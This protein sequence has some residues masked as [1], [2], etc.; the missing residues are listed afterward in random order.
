M[1]DTGTTLS[2]VKLAL[3]ARKQQEAR[4]ADPAIAEPLAIVGMGCRFPGGAE[5][6]AAFWELLLEGRST[7]REIPAERW[8][9]ADWYSSS[10]AAGKIGTAYASMLDG[11]DLFDPVFFGISPREA[12]QMDPQQRLLLEVASEALDDAGLTLDGLRS[13]RTGVFMAVFNADYARQQLGNPREVTQH[14]LAGGARSMASGRLSFL[15][16][17]QGP[18]ITV[19][20][21]CSSSLVAIHLACQ[22]L[23]AGES[24]TAIAG[25]VSLRLR[26][27]EIVALSKLGMLAPDG[28]SKTFDSSA[29]GFGI[30]EGCGVLVLKRLSDA[31]RRNDPV[32]AVIRGTAVNQDG[33]TNALTAPNGLAQQEL[34]RAALRN[35]SIPG[36]A[37]SLIEA[38]GTGTRLGD[39]IEVGALA[40]VVGA[41]SEGA[42]PCALTS[43]KATIGHLEAAAGVAGL[44]RAVLSL[45][46]ET[47]SP[48]GFFRELNPEISLEPTRFFIPTERKA[49]PRGASPRFAGISSFGFSGTNAH[50]IVEEAPA[51]PASH[52][53]G[54]GPQVL[55]V[56]ARSQK[57][58]KELAGRYARE[59]RGRAAGVS[60]DDA[61]YTVNL[62][63]THHE[64]RAAAVVNSTGEAADAFAAIAAESHHPA[65]FR[66]P[67]SYAPGRAAFVFSG[68][69]AQWNRM[70][71]GLYE[72]EPE[73]RKALDECA[74]GILHQA[75]WSLLEVLREEGAGSRLDQTEFAQPAIFSIQIALARLWQA[76]G[77]RP[78][79]VVG[80]SAGE[81]AAAC[82]AGAL[83]LPEAIRVIVS[84]GRVM[85]AATGKGRMAAIALPAAEVETKI[86]PWAGRVCIG[87]INSPTSCVISGDIDIFDDVLAVF[88]GFVQK[89]PV[90]YAFHSHQMKPLQTELVRALGTVETRVPQIPVFSTLSGRAAAE[91]FDA[92]YWARSM[93]EPVRFADAVADMGKGE[94][95][96]FIEIA[97]HAVLST[98]VPQ[99]LADRPNTLVISSMK[100]ATDERTAMLRAAA[101]LHA[102]GHG[103]TW[104]AI[105]PGG[106]CIPLPSYP[107][108]RQRYRL[109]EPRRTADEQASGVFSMRPVRSP[110]LQADV[111][112]TDLH[113]DLPFVAGHEIHGALVVPMSAILTLLSHSAGRDERGGGQF[114]DLVLHEPMIVRHGGALTV[115]VVRA[116]A[117]IEV[118]ARS[119]E[120]WILHA[121]AR[122]GAAGQTAPA[123]PQAAMTAVDPAAHYRAMESRG[124]R[125][126]ATMRALSSLRVSRNAA[127]AEAAMPANADIDASC[128]SPILLDAVFNGVAHLLSLESDALYLPLAVGSAF[129]HAPVPSEVS[130]HIQLRESA[131]GSGEVRSADL[132]VLDAAGQVVASF[133]D[134][135]FKKA[136]GSAL[137]AALA[138]QSEQLRWREE[139]IAAGEAAIA[140]EARPRRRWLVAADRA[141]LA[142]EAVRFLEKAGHSCTVADVDA[143]A[144]AV[145]TAFDGLLH[146]GALDLPCSPLDSAFE[147]SY[148]RFTSSVLGWLKAAEG[149]GG[150]IVLI[151]RGSVAAAS[152]ADVTHAPG[153]LA[154]GLG[155]TLA[156]EHPELGCSLIDLDPASS[157]AE[158]AQ[159]LAA[160][161]SRRL[162]EPEI[163]RRGGKTLV[164][165]LTAASQGGG[166]S[167]RLAVRESGSIES[168]VRESLPDS[169]PAEGE[170]RIR[171]SA[172]GLNFR[173]V[174]MSLGMYE[175][176]AVPL[177]AECAGVVER[178]G[179]GVTR[180]AAGDEVVAFCS[181]AFATFVN[182]DAARAV[183][184]PAGLSRREAASLPVA[185]LTAALALERVA[186][187]RKGESVLI[188]AGAGGLGS[189]AI[190]IALSRGAEVYATAG[191]AEKQEYLRSIGVRRIA[192]SRTLEFE[193]RIREWTGGRGVDVALNCLGGGAI[194]ATL[195]CVA[196]GGHF[197]EVGKRGILTSEQAAAMRPDVTYRVIDLGRAAD[198]D[199]E[200]V[201][202]LF[203][204]M[205][206]ALESGAWKRMPITA[207][208][209]DRAADAF[210][211][212]AQA[213][214]I[215]KVVLEMPEDTRR[216]V[217][218]GASY[219]ITGGTGALGLHMAKALAAQGAGALVLLGRG[220]PNAAAAAVIGELE[221]SGVKVRACAADAADADGLREALDAVLSGLPPLRGI[222]HAAGTLDDGL[223]AGQTAERFAKVA[224]S[225]V[226]GVEAV[227]R[228]AAA[229]DLDFFAVFSSIAGTFGSPGQGS[230]AAANAYLQGAG[231][232][233]RSSGLPALVLNWGV[234]GVGN[235]SGMAGRTIEGRRAVSLR[236]VGAMTAAECAAE[237][238]GCI[239]SG[240]KDAVV[241]RCDWPALAAQLGP[242][243]VLLQ[244]LVKGV[245]APEAA[246]DVRGKIDAVPLAERRTALVDYVRA[247]TLRVLGL[248]PG[249][250]LAGN[251]PLIS[252]G[253]DS[254][255]AV[256]LRNV[257]SAGLDLRL[258]S[259]LVFD[260]PTVDHLAAHLEN[261]L[262][263]GAGLP[264]ADNAPVHAAAAGL[265][266]LSDEEAEALLWAE[267]EQEGRSK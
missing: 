31:L 184:I 47:F 228:Y 132:R 147:E 195:R 232:V 136:A 170:I 1:N 245:P 179:E 260:C 244:N 108:Q 124:I 101:S 208:P 50:I 61:A 203:G 95:T 186:K 49:W 37:I 175:G 155:R 251:R 259:T 220:A 198:A 22:S 266:N 238:S 33:R 39:P 229:L 53:S 267:L 194:P 152:D 253:L 226:Q 19:D 18:S 6:P 154:W 40:E 27:E 56:S 189:A 235:G 106:R 190:H 264:A 2:A 52:P 240:V 54:K 160:T 82:V 140:D 51:L 38:H 159:D 183:R 135:R 104:N 139:W 70:G 167:W 225:K 4:K 143:A 134:F 161:L 169:D 265:E 130:A 60:L 172:A 197:L 153:A 243:A 239:D 263:P 138:R 68:Q 84:R 107:W 29:D 221:A 21:A 81:A 105:Q 137:N 16:D 193:D 214:H 144:M 111:F 231:S 201:P 125:F 17:L 96:A 227:G 242:R 162:P 41:R 254:L 181:H 200:L 210:R 252:F 90:Q 166:E 241:V 218:P 174:L 15:L 55:T 185:Y 114:Q 123:A 168:V 69:G 191:A 71:L 156:L 73:F 26:P 34:V 211:F 237:F 192:S 196:R 249:F 102:A 74:A 150:D 256:E 103:L 62:R 64:F 58:L 204:E 3:L 171:V 224:A 141:G 122:Q 216:A 59:F 163:A 44:M 113:A 188:H 261:A 146:F 78:S 115:Q 258:S 145:G 77:V 133:T 165:R 13:S 12:V 164:R 223:L 176:A 219:L 45:H 126:G 128:Y 234:W 120:R 158:A 206:G 46:H 118:Y 131:G 148:S 36:S 180:F 236:G 121:S 246:V 85:Q 35:A 187:I 250:Q 182:V 23:R 7:V 262:Y 142:G 98:Y 11:V 9:L 91:P 199:P 217:R 127:Y 149:R 215:G 14:T 157:D 230:Y 202:S 87:A 8:N 79:A 129:I 5:S 213:K 20:T 257:L 24:D 100:R 48:H 76:W 109:N 43:V 72:S 247:E 30:G 32:W 86:G 88:E 112:E 94:V 233:R 57:A 177:G 212:M 42:L 65:V 75:G 80:H 255:M 205:A 28:R 83:S 99:I 66:G 207:F 67:Q 89:L 248:S 178:V 93:R 92:A 110:L 117:S 25:G 151:T 10:G 116:N 209:M 222:I 119:G 63:R 97:P 173:D